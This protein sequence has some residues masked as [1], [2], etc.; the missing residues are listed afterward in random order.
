L[1]NIN[2]NSGQNLAVQDKEVMNK[3]KV[4]VI[5][6]LLLQSFNSFSQ[7]FWKIENEYGDEVL[8]TLELNGDKNTFVAYSRKDALKD[9]AGAFTF[10]LA[11]AAGK[12]KYPE[13]VFIEGKTSHKNDSLFLNGNFNYFDKQY[14]FYA[15]ISG[16]HFD[17]KY[18]DTKSRSH[19]LTGIKVP[20]TKPIKDYGLIINT[21][22]FLT[23]KNLINPLWLQSSE[24]MEFR[25]KVNEL[26]M[27]ISDDYELAATYFWLGK[28]LPFSPYEIDKVR[29]RNKSAGRKNV[30]GISELK[31]NTAILNGNSIP[32]NQHDID[33]I[34]G[35]INKMGYSNL[36]ID[37]RGN[38]R[39]NPVSLNLLVS[40]LSDKPF[41]GGVYL[42]RRWT[43]NNKVIP[44][45]KEYQKQFKG[46]SDKDF[47]Q[48]MLYKEPGRYLNVHPNAKSFKGKVYVLSDAKTSKVAEIL[49]YILKVEK[50]ATVVGQ[51]SSGVSFLSENLM[52]NNEFDLILPDSEFY[53]TEGKRVNK[54]GVEADIKLSGDQVMKYIANL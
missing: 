52:I 17:G 35:I 32:A 36:I 12:L 2:R 38:S 33:S 22:F 37:L 11:K 28:K 27:K 26:K 7:T 39:L 53:T 23:E 41:N 8:L 44:M 15:S 40:Y 34:A 50:L 18:T 45:E 6:L 1:R 9:L 25:K 31:R 42:T 3:I 54:D 16:G 49:V 10:A 46:F 29:S 20:D 24:W 13:I 14:L 51:K 19:P 5:V 48:G 47:Q 21:A 43:D 4:L 30:A